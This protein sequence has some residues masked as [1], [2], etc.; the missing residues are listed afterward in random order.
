M[1]YNPLLVVTTGPFPGSSRFP[2]Y[3]SQ[4]GET[5]LITEYGR[6]KYM[7]DGP[8]TTL[9]EPQKRGT[10]QSVDIYLVLVLALA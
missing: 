8:T 9:A 10:R 6:R 5:E 7:V 2:R 4:H 1:S 3:S